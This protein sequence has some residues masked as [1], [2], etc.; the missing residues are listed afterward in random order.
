MPP[1]FAKSW[2]LL[3]H[4]PGAVG[5]LAQALGCSGIVAQ[6]LLNRGLTTPT[7]ARRFLDAPLKGLHQPDLLPGIPQAVDLIFQAIKAGKKIC[8]YGDYDVDGV[9]GA[10]ILL[11]VLKLLH[12][13][14]EL[15]LPHRLN[16]G[17]GLNCAALREIARNGAAVVVTVDCGI[18]SVEEADEARKLG[19]ELIVTDHHEFKEVLPAAVLVHPRLPGT[20]YPF[21]K[22]SGSAVAFK[23]AWALAQR[24]SGGDRVTPRFRDFLLDAVAL[25]SLGIVADVVPLH[26]ENRILVRHGLARLRQAPGPGLKA[27]CASAGLP[28]GTALRSSDIGYRIA[29]RLNAAGRLGSARRVVE[30]LTTLCPERALELAQSLEEANLRR[31]EL[32][33]EMVHQARD[34]I[35]QAN[36]ANDPALVLAYSGW[37]PGILGIVAGRMAELYARP[38]LMIA[39]PDGSRSPRPGAGLRRP[40]TWLRPVDRR[41]RPQRSPARL[42]RFAGRLRRPSH[43][44]R[45]SHAAGPYR[46]LPRAPV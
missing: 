8:V 28:A 22:L 3:P 27:L 25:A 17:Y 39:L 42:R 44:G 37:H 14:V 5:Q 41:L 15:Y 13:Q 6:L 16:E 34:L 2:Q 19:L 11:Q 30:L 24:D 40:G 26:D 7:A 38:A 23:L 31:Q 36:L 18:A 12:A 9:S 35:E 33:R 43:G 20:S 1:L 21:G 10:A 46:R 45:F 4:D 32:E 29:P